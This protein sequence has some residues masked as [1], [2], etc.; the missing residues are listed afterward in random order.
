VGQLAIGAREDL[1]L[2]DVRHGA[3]LML[4][5]GHHLEDLGRRRIDL[6][7]MFVAPPRAV[8]VRPLC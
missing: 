1:R 6:A 5:V 8:K 3:D 7:A 4:I 2:L